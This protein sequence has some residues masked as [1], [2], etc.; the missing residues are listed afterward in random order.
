MSGETFS[1]HCTE[2][3]IPP[4]PVR[5]NYNLTHGLF[6]DTSAVNHD[7]AETCATNSPTHLPDK[8]ILVT[9]DGPQKTYCEGETAKLSFAFT[10]MFNYSDG[11]LFLEPIDGPSRALVDCPVAFTKGIRISAYSASAMPTYLALRDGWPNCALSYK[12]IVRSTPDPNDDTNIIADWDSDVITLNVTNAVPSVLSVSM[13]D[14]AFI[15]GTSGGMAQAVVGIQNVFEVEAYDPSDIDLEDDGFET[16]VRFYENGSVSKTVTL[17]GNPY[18]QQIPHAFSAIGRNKMTVQVYDKDM[19]PDER[20]A[21]DENPFTVFVETLNAP[22]IAL[23]SLNNSAVFDETETGSTRGRINVALTVPPTMLGAGRL[24]VHLDVE[25]VGT[26]DGNYA[27]PVLNTTDLQFQSPVTQQSVFFT[28]LD[29]TPQ[30]AS[31]G[32]RLRARVTTNTPSLDAT[33][34]LA[35]CYKEGTF[36]FTVQNVAPEIGT[37]EATQSMIPATIGTPY[38]LA[39][40]V[41]DVEND[42]KAMSVCWEYEGTSEKSTIDVSASKLTKAITFT[43]AGAKRVRLSAYDKDGGAC[44]RDYCFY[45]HP[46]SEVVDVG[47]SKTVTVPGDWLGQKTVRTA[48]DVAANGRKVWECYLLGCDPEQADDDFR[49]ISFELKDGK[50]IFT[51]SHTEDGSGSSLAPRIRTLGKARIEDAD[52]SEVPDGNESAF[53]FFKAEVVLP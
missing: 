11:Y 17:Y 40:T 43:T 31:A 27:L 48:A 15:Y 37:D 1:R 30:S 23:T 35:E 44:V 45:V 16:I 8:K 9:A 25:R 21:A 51:F 14:G 36:S 2:Y 7:H 34:T 39:W 41:D 42:Q 4:A 22:T 6:A 47:D 24:T 12:V 38:S 28:A 3:I 5:W 46:V 52:W 10:E 29:G 19:S 26:D 20:L 13:M 33:K 18:G 53:R 49:I 32:F 50:P